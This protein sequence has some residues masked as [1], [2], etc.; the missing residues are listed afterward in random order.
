MN[1]ARPESI[2]HLRNKIVSESEHISEQEIR[3][4]KIAHCQMGTRTTLQVP[5]LGTF[6]YH[7][8]TTE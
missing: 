6:S 5:P 1:K 3:D 4:H 7:Q 8:L 2:P